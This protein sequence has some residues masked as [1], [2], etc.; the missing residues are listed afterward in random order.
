MS[1]LESVRFKI[2]DYRDLNEKFDGMKC[3][4]LNTWEES[5]ET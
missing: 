3:G 2:A 5:F 1:G 4:C